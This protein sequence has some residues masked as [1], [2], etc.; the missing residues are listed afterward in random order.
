[1]PGRIQIPANPVLDRRIVLLRIF[2]LRHA[3][4][5]LAVDLEVRVLVAVGKIDEAG[6]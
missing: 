1:M 4:H 3:H 6:G 2:D 5:S